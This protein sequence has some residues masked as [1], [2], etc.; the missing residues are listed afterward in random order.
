MSLSVT[1]HGRYTSRSSLLLCRHGLD[2][3]TGSFRFAA[4]QYAEDMRSLPRTSE[5][6]IAQ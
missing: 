4:D 1:H 6:I 2:N 5:L 3:F